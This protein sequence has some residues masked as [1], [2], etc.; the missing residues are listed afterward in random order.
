MFFDRVNNNK[1]FMK[2]GLVLLLAAAGL[3]Y[4]YRSF[5]AG[6]LSGDLSSMLADCQRITGQVNMSTA[7]K[8]ILDQTY[9][10][11]S[12]IAAKYNITPPKPTV[13]PF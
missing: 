9:A 13:L 1:G 5:K 3:W 12:T 7:D 2:Q 6:N 11:I 10:T 8:A 4:G